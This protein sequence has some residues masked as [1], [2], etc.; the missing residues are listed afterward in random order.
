[1]QL[2]QK[3]RKAFAA[4]L[5]AST[6]L[7]GSASLVAPKIASAAVHSE[8]CLVLSGGIVW[9]ITNGTRRGYTSAEVFQSYGYN[10]SQVV[11][12]SAEDVA[13]PVGPIMIYADGTLVKGPNDPLV[14]LVSGGQKRPFVSGSVFTGLGFSFANIQSAPVNT[15]SDLPTGANLD[16]TT[17]A[18]PDGVKVISNGTVWE[19][20]ATGR[21]GFASGDNFLSYGYKFAHVVAAN[22][23]DLAMPDQGAVPARPACNEM[24]NQ[25]GSV[26][27]TLA[28]PASSTL[29]VDS[30]DGGNNNSQS[31][32]PLSNFVFSGNGTVTSVTLMRTGVSTDS[33]LSNV[34]L[35]DGSTRLTDAGT[36]SSNNLTFS[37]ANGLFS[38]SGSKTITV[39]ADLDD[40]SYSGQTVGVNLTAATLSAGTVGGLSVV[41]NMHTVAAASLATVAVGAPTDSGATDPGT[42]IKVW[43]STFTVG[44]RD[45]TFSRLSLRQINNIV[46]ADVRNFRLLVDG[47]QVS[48]V[49]SID[50]NGY[51]T[52]SG[53]SKVLKSG[54]PVVKVIADVI[55]GSSRTLEMSLRNKADV[56][57]MDSQFNVNISASGTFPADSDGVAINNGTVSV[58]R[59]VDSPSGN[60]TNNASNMK[61]GKWTVT[62]YGESVKIENLAVAVDNVGETNADYTLRNGKL[63][64]NG[65]QVGATSSLVLAGAATAAATFSTNFTVVPGTPATVELYAD[66]Y[67]EEDTGDELAVDDILQAYLID[68]D[69]TNATA[70]VSLSTFDVPTGSDV[71]ANQLTIKEGSMT[72]AALASYP[73]Q[74]TVVPQTNFKLGS[75]TL[76]G[77]STEDINLTTLSVD[78]NDVTGATFTA[79]DLSDLYV[80][81]GSST[82]SI[83]ATPAVSDNDWSISYTLMKNTVLTIELWGNIKAVTGD[84]TDTH[85]TR[86]DLSVTGTTVQSG[87]AASQLDV[88]GQTIIKNAGSF[89]TSVD[90]SSP[91]ARLID[92]SGTVQ[93]AAFKVQSTYDTVNLT[94]VDV[95]ISTASAVQSLILKKDGVQLGSTMPGA[96]STLF[97]GFN[98]NVPA[99]TFVILTVDAVMSSVGVGAG[100]SGSAV[101]AVLDSVRYQSAS[102]GALTLDDNNRTANA[103]YAFKA[104]PTITNV[105]L[106]TG[107]LTTGTNTLAKFTV[108]SNGTGTVAWK[109]ILFTINKTNSADSVAIDGTP[110]VYDADTGIEVLGTPTITTLADTDAAGSIRF[111]ATSEQEV[112]G[113]KTYVLKANVTSVGGLAAGDNINTSIA[114]SS[115]TIADG[116]TAGTDNDAAALVTSGA[117]F[118]WS[119]MSAVAHSTATFDW[120]SDYL[121][122][123]LPTDSQVLSK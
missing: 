64:V 13:L 11:A 52:F 39:R 98:V 55:G 101:T 27:V 24:P 67:D 104:V 76:T 5:A 105:A 79:A 106:P 89:V 30:T 34:Y 49:A 83:K 115:T 54:A 108:S 28:G 66:I 9:M 21:M 26:N 4:T 90:A 112:S 53:F 36:F 41:G 120:Y 88:V 1:M 25:V 32:A 8:G 22:A 14:Y 119:D 103:I 122:K 99:N 18:H 117:N 110:K 58:T 47:V 20:T 33:M 116:A 65:S 12:A 59:A 102:S 75:W 37:N 73:N 45:V 35:F 80:K 60:I 38:V 81:Y 114:N 92:D 82:T 85:S 23:A 57:L 111:S 2:S 84:I 46:N 48:S 71:S 97:T 70:Q 42:D 109:N 44:V 96:T 72:L 40:G 118:V 100:V 10:F 56:E 61:L 95:N 113:A 3:A 51:V 6:M 43:E 50:A 87:V 93:I 78:F 69:A 123:N 62:A 19:M 94:E 91:S 7:M 107:T 17:M 74:T 15:F 77:S 68:N 63:F 29:I 86:A 31:L 121:V 16:S